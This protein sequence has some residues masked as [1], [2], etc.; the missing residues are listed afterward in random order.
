MKLPPIFKKSAGT[1]EELYHQAKLGRITDADLSINVSNE[2][3]GF[4]DKK[5]KYISFLEIGADINGEKKIYRSGNHEILVPKKLDMIEGSGFIKNLM[6]YGTFYSIISDTKKIA[7]D[8]EGYGCTV[9]YEGK[10]YRDKL[11]NE[12][13]SDEMMKALTSFETEIKS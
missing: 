11:L 8:L 10:P 1:L 9:K 2:C 4:L 12:R 7:K 6:L 5:N 3:V 13:L